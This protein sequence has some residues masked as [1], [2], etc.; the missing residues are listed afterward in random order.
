MQ[1]SFVFSVYYFKGIH[2]SC[3]IVATIAGDQWCDKSSVKFTKYS[4]FLTNFFRHFKCR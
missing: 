2:C 1:I 3:A 4:E